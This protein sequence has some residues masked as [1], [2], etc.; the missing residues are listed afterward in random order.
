MFC[1]R[2]INPRFERMYVSFDAQVKG[3][4]AGCRPFIGLD[5]THVK[6]PNGGQILTAQ[7]R[8]A[9][10][11][12]FP[13][14]F[15][16]VEAENGNAWTWFLELLVKSIGHGEHCGGWTIMSDRQ[17]VQTRLAS[18]CCRYNLKFIYHNNNNFLCLLQGLKDGVKVV[19][20]HAEHRYCLR[21]LYANFSRAGFK[22]PLLKQLMDNAAYAYKEYDFQQAMAEIKKVNAKAWKWLCD[23]DSKH[24]SRHR[25]TP[26][27]K[28]DLVVNNIS[29][30]YNAWIL[31]AREEPVCTMVEHIRTKLMESNSTKGMVQTRTYGS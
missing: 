1:G 30:S 6:L 18:M 5:G 12:L 20:P 15:A 22:G 2:K 11:N 26:N 23:I 13:I 8:D 7:G 17:K 31:E 14:A 4:Q 3:F 25:F 21:H 27:A 29:E 28:T 16:L 19:F 9:N 10:N 24:W